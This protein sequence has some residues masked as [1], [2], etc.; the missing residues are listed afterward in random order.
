MNYYEI[1]GVAVDATAEQIRAARKRAATELHPDR[2]H[3]DASA[4]AAVNQACAVLLDP[5]K[6]KQYDAQQGLNRHCFK[7]GGMKTITISKGFKVRTVPCPDCQGEN[8]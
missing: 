2:H 4:M 1:V 8:K 3:G 6:R 5:V 7:C